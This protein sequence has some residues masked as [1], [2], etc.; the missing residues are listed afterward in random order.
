MY[1][2]MIIKST[3]IFPPQTLFWVAAVKNQ[4]RDRLC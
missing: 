3:L 1:S 2:N 4:V